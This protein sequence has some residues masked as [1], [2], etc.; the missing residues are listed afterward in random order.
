MLGRTLRCPRCK[1]PFRT[2]AAAE[3]PLPAAPTPGGA[4]QAAPSPHALPRQIGRF[5]VRA[6]LGTGAFG[7]VYRAYDPQLDREVALKVPLPGTL[8]DPARR[9]RFLREARAAAQL[10]HPHIVPLFETGTEPTFYLAS[11]F[12]EGRTLAAALHD[13]RLDF[14]DAARIVRDLAAAL[15]YAHEQGIIH[16]DVKPANVILDLKGEP[17]L[18]DFGLAHRRSGEEKLTQEGDLL[19]TPDYMAPELVTDPDHAVHPKADQY[20]LGVTLYELLTGQTPFEGPREAVLGQAIYGEVPSP[21]R[22]RPG[23]PRDLET[24]CLKALSKRP[25]ERYD[26]CQ[27]LAEDLRRW[28]DDEPIHARSLGLAE[29]GVRWVRR[30]PA[31]AS[32]L[33]V[34]VLTL[35]LGSSVTAFFA[36]RAFCSADQARGEAQRAREAERQKDEQLDRVERLAYFTR[37]TLAQ[38]EWQHG[39][40]AVAWHHLDSCQWN[41]RGWEHNY[42][43]TEFTKN[44]RTFRGHTGGVDCVAF[45]PDGKRIVS[46][47]ADQT[48][49]VWDADK[50]SETLALKGHTREVTC[51]AF[52]PDGQR[53]VSGSSDNT[54]VWDASRA[55]RPSP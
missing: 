24:I 39:D 18:L 11:A 32:L 50:G 41:L 35:L 43:Y 52:S 15:T 36:W 10:R 13:G 46:G 14:R 40:A 5:Q 28:L 48:L 23:L 33:A 42:L 12:I 38:Q 4:I 31:V 27:D 37:L 22:V 55:A 3:T 2:S 45:S 1:Q 53:I 49:K 8:D 21:T 9:E 29:R 20:A 19:G 30:N 47:G 44:Q 7:T 16:R 51:V 25:E 34:V 26:G 17:H 6:W 54:N